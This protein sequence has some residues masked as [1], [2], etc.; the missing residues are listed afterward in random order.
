M[1][2]E[3]LDTPILFGLAKPVAVQGNFPILFRDVY[4]TISYSQSFE[5]I[6]YRV[7]S[8]PTLPSEAR[9]R[10]DSQIYPENFSNYRQV[11]AILDP[12]IARLAEQVTA[13][14]SNSYEKAR[15]VEGYLQVNLGYTLELRAGGA[16]P[17]A[18]FLFNVR[19]G[20]CEYFATA[21]AIMLRTQGIPT[22]IVNGFHGG[23][24]NDAADVS[25]VRQRNAHAWVEVYFPDEKAWVP[26]D[27][28]P[29]IGQ[30]GA[31]Q[32]A[33]AGGTLTKYFEA[34]ETFWIQYFVAF[35]NQEQLSLARTVR[36]R[37]VEY[38]S[39]LSNL[40]RRT[41]ERLLAWLA[42]VRG[43][44]G[45][46]AS[47]DAIVTASIYLAV[48]V[49]VFLVLIFSFKVLKRLSVWRRIRDRLFRR[50]GVTVVEFYERMQ[51]ILLQKGFA[52]PSHQTPLEFASTTGHPG[53]MSITQAYQDVRFG[54]TKLSRESEAE[55]ENILTEIRADRINSGQ[56]S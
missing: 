33:G 16:E 14:S 46:A 28:T 1:F 13:K 38:Q 23:D 36:N 43:D 49:L 22:R 41:Q 34:L 7:I 39:G 5:R 11:P 30:P 40:V 27:P 20:H 2:L 21:M 9:L 4:G 24:Y 12:R 10:S 29:A 8:E 48:G 52:R 26:F 50:R 15:A 18:D 6:S 3:P 51:T 54:A 32:A 42:E 47:R 56:N 19:E 25:V 31:N 17:L 55:I 53:V 37:F 44:K 45:V 35:D